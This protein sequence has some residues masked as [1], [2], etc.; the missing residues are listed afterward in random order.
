MSNTDQPA[1]GRSE[2]RKAWIFLIAQVVVVLASTLAPDVA[3]GRFAGGLILDPA[4]ANQARVVNA[5]ALGSACVAIVA[6]RVSVARSRNWAI[7]GATAGLLASGTVIVATTRVLAFV[8]KAEPQ[9]KAGFQFSGYAALRVVAVLVILWSA[10]RLVGRLR[11]QNGPGIDE[12]DSALHR[13]G[14]DNSRGHWRASRGLK[15]FAWLGTVLHLV[16]LAYF[17]ATGV[18]QW[19]RFDNSDQGTGG[20]AVNSLESAMPW[21]LGVSLLAISAAL[22]TPGVL[23]RTQRTAIVCAV[24]G[25]LASAGV[26]ATFNPIQSYPQPQFGFEMFWF[27][28]FLVLLCFEALVGVAW[29]TSWLIARVAMGR[30]SRGASAEST[31]VAASPPSA[32]YVP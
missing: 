26:I 10:F 27:D 30:R 20:V 28:A 11:P 16:T 24:V 3:Q 5:L 21:I 25:L 2:V 4:Y 7:L 31:A 22:S 8:E 1:W 18:K 29:F 23:A 17:W 15:V 19:A 32:T 12:Q 14:T 6:T 9:V 13:T